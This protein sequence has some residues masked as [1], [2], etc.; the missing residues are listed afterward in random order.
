MKFVLILANSAD[1]DE[2]QRYAVFHLGLHCLPKYPAWRLYLMT[3]IQSIMNHNRSNKSNQMEECIHKRFKQ[4]LILNLP[5]HSHTLFRKIINIK[6]FFG[7][8]CE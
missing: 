1:L 3:N 6:L 7:I 8:Y 2:M 4:K 5:T